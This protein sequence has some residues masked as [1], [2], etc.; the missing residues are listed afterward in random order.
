MIGSIV[1]SNQIVFV[2]S[3]QLMDGVLVINEVVDFA[4]KE[5]N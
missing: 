3:R 5:K 1:S 2:P 4:R